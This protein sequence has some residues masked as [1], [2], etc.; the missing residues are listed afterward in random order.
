MSYGWYFNRTLSIYVTD[1]PYEN[2]FAAW[3]F[4]VVAILTKMFDP[5]E[6]STE[7]SCLV[8]TT[9]LIQ[10]KLFYLNFLV[11]KIFENFMALYNIF[12]IQFLETKYFNFG[13]ISHFSMHWPRVA[14]DMEWLFNQL[15][16][17]H[18]YELYLLICLLVVVTQVLENYTSASVTPHNL[19]HN[20]PISLHL[21]YYLFV[22]QS[23]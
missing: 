17:Q 20:V 19:N 13:H 5:P 1:Q 2:M 9:S 11:T 4:I 14:H 7:Y 3:F 10:S 12:Q 15:T 6:F 21:C 8:C 16:W 18:L 22:G 23:Y